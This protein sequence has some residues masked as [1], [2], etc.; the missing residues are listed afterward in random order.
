MLIAPDRTS[1]HAGKVEHRHSAPAR[2]RDLD[3]DDLVV[4]FVAAQPLAEG[5]TRGGRGGRAHQRIEHPLLGVLLGLRAHFLAPRLAH[6]RQADFDEIADDALDVAADVADLR[7]LRRLDLEERRARELRE[8]ARD[9]GFA[10][11]SRPIIRMFFGSTSSL[12]GPSSCW[13]R[14]RLRSAM[15]TARLAS[16]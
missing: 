5:F 16:P 13:R 1:G 9:L 15:A 14:H 4:E 8:A 2:I 6:Q 7:E 12:S 3:L 10:D 11:A